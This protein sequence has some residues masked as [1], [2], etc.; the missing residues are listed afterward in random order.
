MFFDPLYLY[1][2]WGHE[3]L[4]K[5]FDAKSFMNPRNFE[6]EMLMEKYIDTKLSHSFGS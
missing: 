1:F 6:P 3:N 5:I 4:N 2:V